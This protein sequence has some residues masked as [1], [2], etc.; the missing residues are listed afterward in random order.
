MCCEDLLWPA[1]GLQAPCRQ[2]ASA[3]PDREGGSSIQQTIRGGR[4][5]TRGAAY[6]EWIAGAPIV[7]A[8]EL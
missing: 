6:D 4:R 2:Y 7:V 1:A 8:S 5:L 3:R